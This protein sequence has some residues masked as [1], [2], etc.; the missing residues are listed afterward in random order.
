MYKE[1]AIDI[2]GFIKGKTVNRILLNK[3][4]SIIRIKKPE[5][6]PNINLIDF[7]YPLFL[8]DISDMVLFGPGVN[9]VTNT[10]VSVGIR[11]NNPNSIPNN[12]FS[13]F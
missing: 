3:P 12:Y 8:P 9:V 13:C 2:Y 5:N 1:P 10:N 11:L 4:Q 7:L 6:I